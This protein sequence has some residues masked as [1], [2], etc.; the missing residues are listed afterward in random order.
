MPIERI[1]RHAARVT[2]Y[3]YDHI[4]QQLCPDAHCDPA[5]DVV[6]VHDPMSV[7]LATVPEA[8][9]IYHG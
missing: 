8:V 4:T 3:C 2:T 5:D 9:S 7:D 1:L 6:G